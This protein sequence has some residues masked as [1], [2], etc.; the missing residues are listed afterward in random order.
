MIILRFINCKI[1]LVDV[2]S[3][4]CFLLAIWRSSRCKVILKNRNF[5]FDVMILLYFC[6]LYGVEII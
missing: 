1:R 3:R 6:V 2:I 5:D 4:R